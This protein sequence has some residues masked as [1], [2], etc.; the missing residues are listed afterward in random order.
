[1]SYACSHPPGLLSDVVVVIGIV[2][3]GSAVV[4]VAMV[5][6]GVSNKS[7]MGAV[8]EH[9]GSSGSMVSPE[10]IVSWMA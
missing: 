10:A 4:V 9:F 5:V 2:V 8:P 6:V 1:M 7:H 3:V